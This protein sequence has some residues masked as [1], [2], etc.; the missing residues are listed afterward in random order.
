MRIL[1]APAIIALL[2]QPAYSQDRFEVEA[3][4]ADRER[5]ELEQQHKATMD[6]IPDQTKKKSDPWGAV[7][8]PEPPQKKS[9]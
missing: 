6:R 5:K 1:V 8:S 3:S 9:N 7:R 2:I 4:K